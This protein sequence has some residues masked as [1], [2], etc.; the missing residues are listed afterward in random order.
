MVDSTDILNASILIVDDQEA[1]VLLLERILR[2][3][4]YTCITSTTAP[5]EVSTM[6][7]MNGYDLI[8]LD[9]AMPGMDGFQV[10]ENLKAIERDGYL[11]VLAI[12]AHPGHQLRALQGG[13]KDFVSKPFETAEVL[14]RVHNMLEVRLLHES[15]RYHG[16]MLESLSRID[17]LTDLANRR[18]LG[19]RMTMALAHA[20]RRGT[21]MAVVYLDLD[22]FKQVNDAFGHPAG[23]LLLKMVAG[24]LASMVRKEDT[25]ARMGGD[26]FIIVLTDINRP[27]S[28]STVAAKALEAVSRSY[29]IEGHSIRMTASAGIGIYP[30]HGEDASTLIKSADLA[31]YEAKRAG[32]N[33]YRISE[34][35]SRPEDPCIR[36]GS[37]APAPPSSPG[38]HGANLGDDRTI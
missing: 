23:D 5:G 16:K 38:P 26:E 37:A 21:A 28:A 19:E 13:A 17:P 1:H 6:H 33:V 22:G 29:S 18:L 14:A 10:M 25:L 2:Q 4:G 15:A 7:R 11:P 24:R 9:L 12:T 35:I 30:L 31:L 8:L 36:S 32:G 3:A 27:E 20:R 34:R